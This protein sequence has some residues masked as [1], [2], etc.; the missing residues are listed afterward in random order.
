M[1]KQAPQQPKTRWYKMLWQAYKVTARGDKALPWLIGTLGGVPIVGGVVLAIVSSGYFTKIISVVL[2]LM[3]GAVL[4][5]LT[6]TRRFERQMIIQLEGQLGGSIAVAQQ[7]RRGWQFSEEPL[8]V[9]AKS[10][11]VVFH[12]VG[13]GGVILLAE[14][15]RSAKRT[16]DQTVTR[17]GKLVPGV[18]VTP[19]YVGHEDGQVPLKALTKAIRA[20]KRQNFGRGLT[21]GLSG[22][23]QESVRARL[24]AVGGAQMSIPK[25]I[26]PARARADR[27]AMRG[28]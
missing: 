7:I 6:L 21:R 2:G 23:D 1:A 20:T 24:R 16:V 19:L 10:R 25:G 12:G 15:G 17:L 13:V 5:L 27:K 28:R 9:E 22:A 8:A 4:G 3:V 18:P 26:D 14:G 11:A